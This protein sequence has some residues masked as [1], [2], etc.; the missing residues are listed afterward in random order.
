MINPNPA[1]RV[2]V[3]HS[4]RLDQPVVDAVSMLEVIKSIMLMGTKL[5]RQI[6]RQSRE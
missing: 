3:I 6:N 2:G 4:M 1:I 5:A